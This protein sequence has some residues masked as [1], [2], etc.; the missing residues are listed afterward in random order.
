MINDSV[1]VNN[2]PDSNVESVEGDSLNEGAD[3]RSDLDTDILDVGRQ[4]E[5]RIQNDINRQNETDNILPNLELVDASRQG[6]TAGVGESFS[7]GVA[8][9][10]A[11]QAAAAAEISSIVDKNGKTIEKFRQGSLKRN[12]DGDIEE[13]QEN[14]GKIIKRGGPGN[15]NNRKTGVDLG[16]PDSMDKPLDDVTGD[17]SN[18]VAG[19]KARRDEASTTQSLERSAKNLADESHPGDPDRPEKKGRAEEGAGRDERIKRP[20]EGGGGSPEEPHRRP[21]E[22]EESEPRRHDQPAKLTEKEVAKVKELIKQLGADSFKE[23]EKA[24][25][26]LIKLGVGSADNPQKAVLP[27]LKEAQKDPDLEI[28]RRAERIVSEILRRR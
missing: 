13:I 27:L 14:D 12:A 20:P 2:F 16:S 18:P 26:E 17:N 28:R 21:D 23:R 15:W 19:K 11:R 10:L 3:F 25:N 4:E 1:E 5:T 8:G 7:S 9:G 24:H 22:T 6:Q